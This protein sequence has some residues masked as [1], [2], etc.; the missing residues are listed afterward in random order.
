L[1]DAQAANGF[2]G[3]ILVAHDGKIIVDRYVGKEFEDGDKPSFWLAS[4]SKPITAIAIF[5]LKEQGKLSLNDPITKFFRDVPADKSLITVGDLLTHTSGFPH[6]YTA[7]G[8]AD[9]DTAIKTILAT[10]LQFKKEDGWHYANLN[11]TLLAAIVE[12]ASGK[13][14]EEYMRRE[15]F[16]PAK[17]KDSGFWGFQGEARIASSPNPAMLEKIDPKVYAAKKSIANWGFRGA[18]GM[19]STTN[20]L[21]KLVTA[22]RGGKILKRSSLEEMWSPAVF[23]RNDPDTKV[24]SGYGWY[25]V[26]RDGK[27]IGV[28][29]T[30]S[31]DVLGHNGV[32]WFYENGD[33]SV[34]LSN[35]GERNGQGVSNAVSS[36]INKILAGRKRS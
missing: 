28:R 7:E 2:K 19:F 22:L 36:A 20:D 9:R 3:S 24:Y 16:D 10:P 35:A 26:T 6:V 14:F 4:N 17:M 21:Y 29:H 5:R 18:T 34:V 30:G 15:I 8:I 32:I 27:R 13:T 31:E 12:I 23:I 33:V 11:F 1:V 25:V